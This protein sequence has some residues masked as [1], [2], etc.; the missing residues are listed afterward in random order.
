MKIIASIL[1]LMILSSCAARP[2]IPTQASKS[3]LP[4]LGAAPELESDT[5]INVDTPLTLADLQGK[6]VLLDM[7]TYG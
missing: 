1:M 2:S 6:V 7:W 3:S 5:W 4:D